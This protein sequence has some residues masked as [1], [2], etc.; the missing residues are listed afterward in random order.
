M[1][2]LNAIYAAA[3]VFVLFS[4]YKIPMINYLF[5]LSHLFLIFL[6]NGVLFSPHYLPDQFKYFHVSSA[7]RDSLD[8][9]NYH[10][11]HSGTVATASLFFS[12]FPIPF[13]DSIFSIAI[14]NFIL[15]SVIFIFLYKK[16]ILEGNALWFYLLYP[17]FAL[18]AGVALREMWILLFMIMSIYLLYKKQLLLAIIFSLPLLLIKTQNFLIF[19]VAIVVYNT[20]IKGSLFSV[21]LL[22]KLLFLIVLFY[23]FI[24]FIGIE[25]IDIVRFNMYVEDGGNK[26]LYIP[27]TS[28]RDL[29]FQGTVGAI[30]MVLKPLPWESS[31][32]L[33]LFQSFENLFIFYFIYKIIKEQFVVKNDFINFLI[34]YFFIAMMV[35][36]LVIFNYGTA[37]RYRFTFELIFILFSMSILYKN[38]EKTK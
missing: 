15:Y 10:Q 27:L 8:F 6:L 23:L 24:S 29:V 25:A 33:Q 12:L 34:V 22:I 18:Y 30:Y 13:L 4:I 32:V 11:Y 37:A 3:L 28:Y 7:I 9:I 36:G 19:V 1:D 17:S 20:I 31:N 16:N 38:R 35:Y 2:L 5:V 26:L 14:I 21:K